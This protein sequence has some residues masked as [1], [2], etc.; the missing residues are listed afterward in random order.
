MKSCIPIHILAVLGLICTR[1]IKKSRI[2]SAP[3]A[4]RGESIKHAGA[5]S[6][7]YSKFTIL[8]QWLIVTTSSMSSLIG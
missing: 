6:K 7:F 3:S 2:G 5:A 4:P 1:Q 8:F